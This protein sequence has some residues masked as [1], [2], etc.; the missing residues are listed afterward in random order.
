MGKIDLKNIKCIKIRGLFKNILK[1]QSI[2]NSEN[3]KSLQP[4]IENTKKILST[5]LSTTSITYLS[6]ELLQ[7]KK[8]REKE[9]KIHLF[10][11]INRTRK[12][13]ESKKK[14]TE[15]KLDIFKKWLRL[16]ESY[17]LKLNLKIIIF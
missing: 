17:V 5:M 13:M 6:H 11:Q 3:G 12:M 16:V 10:T 9:E 2:D 7:Q 14:D 4:T 1:R 15:D 8:K